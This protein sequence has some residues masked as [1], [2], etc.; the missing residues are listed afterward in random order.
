MLGTLMHL[1]EQEAAVG[2]SKA[3]L[4]PNGKNLTR[5][6]LV[7]GALETAFVQMVPP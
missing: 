5:D 3:I 2:T 4:T 7:I 1:E 6:G